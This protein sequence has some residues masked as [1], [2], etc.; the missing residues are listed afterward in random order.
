[1]QIA[2]E[3]NIP[4][5]LAHGPRSIIRA[6]DLCESKIKFDKRNTTSQGSHLY[7]VVLRHNPRARFFSSGLCLVRNLRRN[8]HNSHI[9]SCFFRATSMYDLEDLRKISFSIIVILEDLFSI[10][11]KSESKVRNFYYLF[12]YLYKVVYY[13]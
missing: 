4:F 7:T 11:S 6:R 2:F 5:S 1:M 13:D 10:I 9:F 8:L 12:T 3:S